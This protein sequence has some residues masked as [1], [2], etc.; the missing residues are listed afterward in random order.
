MPVRKDKWIVLTL[1]NRTAT[2]LLFHRVFTG[3]I[4][5]YVI[6]R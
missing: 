6:C 2:L 1:K 4:N 5:G 3:A